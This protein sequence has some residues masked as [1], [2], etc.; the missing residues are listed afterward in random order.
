MSD[1]PK[2]LGLVGWAVLTSAAL[3]LF[4]FLFPAIGLLRQREGVPEEKSTLNQLRAAL[5]FYKEEYGAFPAGDAAQI[6]AALRGRNDR[7]IIIYEARSGT[8]NPKGELID[9]WGTPYRF[10]LSDPEKP[11]VWSCGKN[12]RD[13]GGAEGS[14][15]IPSWR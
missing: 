9:P 7:E 14:D 4:G 10:D 2:K 8:V 11:R 1:K 3:L 5:R 15:D 6:L 12:R 13:D